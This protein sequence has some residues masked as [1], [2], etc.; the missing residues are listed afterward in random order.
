MPFFAF[1]SSIAN[2][3]IKL[4][5]T[6]IILLCIYWQFLQCKLVN[7][8][9]AIWSQNTAWSPRIS[10]YQCV[11]ASFWG[12]QTEISMKKRPQMKFCLFLCLWG[13]F[14]IANRCSRS[15]FTVYYSKA[16]G[17]GLCPQI[18]QVSQGKQDSVTSFFF[19]FPCSYLIAPTENC[20]LVL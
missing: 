13:I 18:N 20:D 9:H 11:T 17:S 19:F 6:F 14:L 12:Q 4:D 8:L 7:F 10:L 16:S 15:V 1:S 5:N 3:K 2:E